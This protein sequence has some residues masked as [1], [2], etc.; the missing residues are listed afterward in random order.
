MSEH[1]KNNE[2]LSGSE[3]H[4]L[5]DKI[6]KAMAQDPE[7]FAQHV[8]SA[9]RH[10]SDWSSLEKRMTHNPQ[11]SDHLKDLRGKM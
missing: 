4:N 8:D 11:L 10:S 1:L 5:M 3:L 7:R 9:L 6:E 2:S